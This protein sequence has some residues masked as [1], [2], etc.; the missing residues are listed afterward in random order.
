MFIVV[1]KQKTCFL[2][3]W[4]L[5]TLEPEEPANNFA[6]VSYIFPVV[7]ILEHENILEDSL[8]LTEDCDSS[9]SVGEG[10]ESTVDN[11]TEGW[12]QGQPVVVLHDSP[13]V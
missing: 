5:F 1:L 6:D 9:Q 10:L 7:L 11:F 13:D 12:L 3:S 8:L 4:V 2:K